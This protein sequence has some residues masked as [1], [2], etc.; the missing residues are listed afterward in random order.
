MARMGSSASPSSACSSTSSVGCSL[1]Q[2]GSELTTAT[3]APSFAL[4][5]SCFFVC[6]SIV[7]FTSA[8]N[9]HLHA[10]PFKS[11]THTRPSAL[12][13]A[14]KGDDQ[15]A[16]RLTNGADDMMND[17]Y[18]N[19]AA[20]QSQTLKVRSSEVVINVAL[21]FTKKRAPVTL[22]ACPSSRRGCGDSP[23]TM[24]LGM[25]ATTLSTA[26]AIRF[27][28]PSHSKHSTRPCGSYTTLLAAPSCAMHLRISHTIT[29]S[30]E[31]DARKSAVASK[32]R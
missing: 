15:S 7:F 24:G 31:A 5:P 29:A 11:C 23:I 28:F 17:W 9:M 27:A 13:V 20:A 2:A 32:R 22:A 26:I 8:V 4:S 14:K 1:F 16:V 12:A 25:T 19:S 21:F 3:S 18:S 10:F 30:A 6:F